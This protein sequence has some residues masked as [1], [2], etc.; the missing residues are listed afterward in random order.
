VWSDHELD[1]ARK[2]YAVGCQNADIAKFLGRSKIAIKRLITERKIKRN[3]M[4]IVYLGIFNNEREQ[5]R[6]VRGVSNYAVSN[7]GRVM[8]LHPGRLGK[9]LSQWVDEDGYCH[10]SLQ[11]IG[12]AKRYSIHQMVA[13]AF[14]GPPPSSGHEVAHGDGNPSNNC[15]INLRWAT[16]IENHADRLIHKTAD[17]EVSGKFKKCKN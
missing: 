9:I 11:G 16:K 10:V 15:C 13:T 14:I 6:T 5:W 3:P 4:R 17:R 1:Q 12:G 8:S 2:M 7:I